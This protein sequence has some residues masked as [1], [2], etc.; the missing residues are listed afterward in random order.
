MKHI[1][2]T[3][4]VAAGLFAV[5]VLASSAS[6][7]NGVAY[8]AIIKGQWVE[9]ENLLRQGLKQ[10]PNDASRL[11]N[12]AFV[13]QNTGRQAEATSLYE[14]VLQLTGNPV[15]AVDDPYVLPQPMRAK[16][17]AKK[18]MASLENAKR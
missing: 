7:S 6:D 13:L 3:C 10:D 4:A 12:L 9:A 18:G 15:V 1:L 16:S 5:P 17:L 8:K 14:K 2:M 11:L